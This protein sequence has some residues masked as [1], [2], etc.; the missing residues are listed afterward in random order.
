MSDNT[1]NSGVSADDAW[2]AFHEIVDVSSAA[3]QLGFIFQLSR[4]NYG[5]PLFAAF[6]VAKPVFNLF[7]HGPKVSVIYNHLH[8]GAFNLPSHSQLT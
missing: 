3:T 5:G 4:S 7:L 8:A 6:C 2:T 1:S